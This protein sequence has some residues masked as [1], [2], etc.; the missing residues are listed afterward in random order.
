MCRWTVFL[1]LLIFY[2]NWE[3]NLIFFDNFLLTL[4]FLVS[5]GSWQLC[6]VW[7]RPWILG[8]T[9]MK[10]TQREGELCILHVGMLRYDLHLL[11]YPSRKL[12]IVSFTFL[13]Y[14]ILC[15]L[16]FV[17]HYIYS[18]VFMMLSLGFHTYRW[19]WSWN[20]VLSSSL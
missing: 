20:K 19:Y 9:K 7:R 15:F 16:P 1:Y 12:I 3:L 18:S 5:C 17:H 8:Q 14:Y 10:R 13:Y 6:R 11:N 4:K 2:Q